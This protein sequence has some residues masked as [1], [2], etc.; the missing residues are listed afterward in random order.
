[1]LTRSKIYAVKTKH[2]HEEVGKHGSFKFLFLTRA[3]KIAKKKPVKGFVF[4]KTSVYKNRG[5]CKGRLPASARTDSVE[6]Q[7]LFSACFSQQK[8]PPTPRE[9]ADQKKL[10]GLSPPR[11]RRGTGGIILS[12]SRYPNQ[13]HTASIQAAAPYPPSGRTP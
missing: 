4:L 3:A 2:P 5:S 11:L 8:N 7:S 9:M 1:M 6:E 10:S 12:T 13:R